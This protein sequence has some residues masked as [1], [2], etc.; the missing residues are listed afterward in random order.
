M[1][2]IATQP[3]G[4]DLSPVMAPVF[5][6]LTVSMILGGISI[7]QAYIYFVNNRDQLVIRLTALFMIALDIASSALVAQSVYS[8]LVP[9]FGSLLPL[10]T[11]TT[12][13]AVD[14]MLSTIITFV[15]QLFFARQLWAATRKRTSFSIPLL[16]VFCS[17]CAFAF[18]TACTVVM[19]LYRH[20]IFLNRNSRFALLF[21]LAKGISALTDVIATGALF[22]FL[23]SSRTGLKGTD[24]IVKTL[25]EYTIERGALVTVIQVVLV[26]I[27]FTSD[28]L[29]WVPLHVNLTKLYANAFFAILNARNILNERRPALQLSSHRHT[30]KDRSDDDCEMP[31]V[32]LKKSVII[33]DF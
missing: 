12:E 20:N 31:A 30:F 10:Q 18:G 19:V 28:R 5:W 33:S 16:I 29:Y 2:T 23:S 13:L 14:C 26:I 7:L 9:H 15:S 24:S 22:T 6:G 3:G 8:Y 25:M 27:F 21:G 1:S 32:T 4:I 17:V 11:F